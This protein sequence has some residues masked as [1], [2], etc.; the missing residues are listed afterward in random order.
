MTCC[1]ALFRANQGDLDKYQNYGVSDIGKRYDI[2]KYETNN[3][4]SRQ[5][6]PDTPR[7]NAGHYTDVG[8]DRP[9]R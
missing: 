9:D 8:S 5:Q 6:C 2:E 4:K 1:Q 3:N 7:W